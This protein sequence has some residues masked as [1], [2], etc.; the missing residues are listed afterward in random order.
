[1]KGGNSRSGG[2]MRDEVGRF[3]VVEDRCSVVIC[4]SERECACVKNEH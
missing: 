1:M 2:G 3:A 4:D